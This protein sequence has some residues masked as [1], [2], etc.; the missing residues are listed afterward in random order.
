MIPLA[1]LGFPAGPER[2]TMKRYVCEKCR[3]EYIFEEKHARR[4]CGVNPHNLRHFCTG[5]IRPKK[6]FYEELFSKPNASVSIPGGE[7]GYAPG[8]C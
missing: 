3:T 4:I 7:P 6:E 5:K 1:L 2:K 8:D